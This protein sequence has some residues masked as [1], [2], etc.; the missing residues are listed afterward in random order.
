M[1]KEFGLSGRMVTCRE[2]QILIHETALFQSRI[3]FN[4]DY[5]IY[6]DSLVIEV[7]TLEEKKSQL[8]RLI[9]IENI[10]A[11]VTMSDKLGID[12]DRVILLINEL[13]SAGE[14]EG[15]LTE[16]CSRFF[17]STVKVSTAPVISREEELPD[18][19]TYTTR[20]GKVVAV[21][22]F[23][24]LAGGLIVNAFALDI[25]EQNFAAIL[26]LIGLLVF[27]IGL[28]LIARRG[29]PD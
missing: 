5:A 18:F 23:L 16:D 1:Y 17:K 15:S 26:I 19:L 4:D 22:G 14:L 12:P 29:T 13:L 21:I 28:Y 25:E 27:L 2:K 20:P 9:M 11:I 3:T 10:S 6:H 24:I 8:I 7:L